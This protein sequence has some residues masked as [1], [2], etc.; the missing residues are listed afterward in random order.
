MTA[1]KFYVYA[2]LREDGSPYYIGKGM[3][4]RASCKNHSVNIP[5]DKSRIIFYQTGLCEADAHNLEIKYIKLFGR[6]DLGTGILR[7]MTD[8]GEGG[9]GCKHSKESVERTRKAHI[10]QKRSEE[11]KQKMRGT[12]GPNKILRGPMSEEHKQKLRESHIG[13][14]YGPMSEEQKELRRGPRSPTGPQK[15]PAIRGPRG[16]YNKQNKDN[17][18]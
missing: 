15:N 16:I 10:G 3:G 6:K 1:Y 13:K 11:S 4:Y 18:L 5:K 14:I 12:R 9:S 8:G 17:I 2:Y 7:N